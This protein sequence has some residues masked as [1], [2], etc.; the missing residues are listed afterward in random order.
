MNGSIYH[1]SS[2]LS[3]AIVERRS[4]TV[5]G[6]FD[7]LATDIQSGLVIG[8]LQDIKPEELGM[9]EDLIVSEV[10]RR[11]EVLVPA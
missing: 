3:L 6:H 8:L 5:A 4:T 10:K 1:L 7:M 9:A 11:H 2:G